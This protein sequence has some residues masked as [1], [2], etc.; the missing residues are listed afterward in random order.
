LKKVKKIVTKEEM[1]NQLKIDLIS[2]FFPLTNE[3]VLKYKDVLNFDRYCLMNNN[4]IYWDKELIKSTIDKIDPTALWKLKNLNIDISF[5]D[6]FDEIIDYSSIQLSRNILW[7]KKIVDKYGEKFDWSKYL[8]NRDNLCNIE[9]IRRFKDKFDWS[10]VSQTLKLPI[11]N[12][13]IDEF[14][15]YIDWKKFSLNENLPISLEFLEKYKD[16]LD[17]DNLSRNPKC[18][19]IILKYPKSKRWFWSNVIIN[20]GLKYNDENFK[21]VFHYYCKNFPWKTTINQINYKIAMFNFLKRIFHFPFTDK[22]YFLNEKFIEF[23][24]WDVFSKS[25]ATINSEFFDKYKSK[26]D[27]NEYEFLRHNGHLIERDFISNNIELF[28]LK[29]YGFYNLDIDISIIENNKNE[30]TW[31]WVASCK[32]LDWSWS[33]ISDNYENLNF[34]RLAENES[35]YNQLIRDKLSNDEIY[36]F[37]ENVNKKD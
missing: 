23:I 26:I 17:F 30:I 2:T 16:N 6:E 11:D 12:N 21:L 29:S 34:Y 33:F 28:N 37:L 5:F 1:F 36:Y 25:N 18:I 35:V 7:D 31:F 4:N 32:N 14:K 13:F 20:S 27:L 8:I 10:S 22:E 9:N 24:P 19:D 15:E 3:D